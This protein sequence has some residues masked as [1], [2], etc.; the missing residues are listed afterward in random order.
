M[1]ERLKGLMVCRK[2][3]GKKFYIIETSVSEAHKNNYTGYHIYCDS[4]NEPNRYLDDDTSE[5]CIIVQQY[6]KIM[7]LEKELKALEK[8]LKKRNKKKRKKMEENK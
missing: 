3:S 4:C 7:Q 8:K 2:C 5:H 1:D 6:S